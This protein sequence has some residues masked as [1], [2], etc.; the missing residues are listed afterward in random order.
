MQPGFVTLQS[1]RD[2]VQGTWQDVARWFVAKPRIFALPHPEQQI[3]FEYA[4]RLR[5][6]IRA[7]VGDAHWDRLYFDA[8]NSTLGTTAVALSRKIL[9]PSHRP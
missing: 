2:L 6:A 1:L 9:C 5:A 7:N 8:S 3:L 4:S